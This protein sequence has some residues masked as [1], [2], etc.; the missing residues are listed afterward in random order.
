M[1]L[2]QI[3]LPVKNGL[4]ADYWSEDA[5][6]H[7]F[8]DY[9]YNDQSFVERASYLQNKTY[10]ME[11]LATVIRVYMEKFGI[12][13]AVE[14]HLTDLEQGAL[15]VVGG[16]QAGVLTGPLYSVHK[17]ISVILLAKEQREKLQIPVV[18]L[19]WIAGEDHDIEE[20]NHTYTIV[21]GQP[22]KRGY[23]ER[24]KRKTMASTT[25]LNQE[26]ME[27]LVRVVFK[28]FGETAYTEGLLVDVLKH[29]RA[30]ETFT[31]FFAT[32]MNELFAKHGLLM[33]DAA[34]GAFRQ[35]EKSFFAAIIQHN[36]QIAKVV[37]EQERELMEAGY[38]MPIEANAD[39]ANLFYVQDGERFLLECKNEQFRNVLAHIKFTKDELLDLA[40]NTPEKLSNN[41]VTRPL[42]QEMTIPVLA[43]VGGPG[44]LAYWATLKGAFAILDLQMPIF[45]P[46]LNITLQTRQVQTLLQQYE[47][48]LMQIIAGEG[49]QLK[50]EFIGSV[51]DVEAAC[52][53]QQMNELLAKQY[54]ELLNHL[55][56][57][58]LDLQKIIEKNK[59]YHEQQFSYLR[60][61]ISQQVLQK[62]QVVLRQF[63]VLQA[64]LLPNEGYQER[65]YNPYQ[66]L[67][68]YGPTL[69]DDLLGL[70]MSI[71][72]QHQIVSL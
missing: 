30:S 41:V 14:Q 15:V 1:K 46:R 60:S 58:Q 56:T 29:V 47:L 35:Y 61:K 21:D 17:A 44:E 4:L 9:K 32:L 54:D 45:A 64:E 28:D 24:S 39:N 70:P 49:E 50:Q 20:I 55:S 13:S 63:D 8:F 34:N 72:A 16:Q 65:L 67:N 12:H 25:A 57:Q 71:C 38:G 19:F 11:Q 43:F 22:K 69:I 53:I 51:Q 18:P 3:S 59:V 66:F 62:H 26:A 42:M 31:D 10:D 52:Q 37:V 36:E 33:I 5:N 40:K 27:Q 48:S 68:T 6:I 2:E 7:T 23:S